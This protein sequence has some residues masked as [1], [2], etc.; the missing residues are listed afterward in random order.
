MVFP[1]KAWIDGHAAVRHN[2]ALSGMGPPLPAVRRALER[3]RPANASA[4][5]RELSRV[6]GVEPAR[7]F[8]THGASEANAIVLQF[9]AQELRARRIHR[10][11]V[12]LPVP[13]YPPLRSAAE[14][15]GFA[16]VPPNRAAA[17]TVLS[18][19]N[20]PTGCHVPDDD[21]ETWAGS[22]HAVVVDETFREFTDAPS[23][24]RGGRP[25]LWT[26]GSF[27]KVY[28]G[29]SIRV[30]YAVAPPEAAERF[31]AFHDIV[32]NG[33]ADASVAA[34]RSILAARPAILAEARGLFRHNLSVL[35]ES[36]PGLS[37]QAPL[38]FD[39]RSGELGGDRLARRLLRQNVLVCPGSLFGDPSGVR[40]CL[41]RRS[42]PSDLAAYESARRADGAGTARST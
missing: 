27:T 38:W 24:S 17:V 18:D 14:Y 23:R 6:V 12:R 7:L 3:P 32:V 26:S 1:L 22:G 31:D 40:V 9:L 2:L 19:P 33:L 29:D 28:G 41:T 8:L 4:L 30:G 20:N 10:P 5:R 35:A 16:P 39:R 15:A 13:E 34:A 21:V 25:G 37:I 42:F 11:R 36:V